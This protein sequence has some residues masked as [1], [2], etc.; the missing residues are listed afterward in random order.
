[1]KT[2]LKKDQ[3]Y[4]EIR[5]RIAHGT[6]TPGQKLPRGVD[7]AKEMGVSHI[8][9]RSA[10]AALERDGLVQSI[11]GRGTFVCR[12]PNDVVI[13]TI[14]LIMP[15][16]GK[17]LTPEQSPT[18][19]SLVSSLMAAAE[20]RQF[21]VRTLHRGRRNFDSASIRNMGVDGL[22]VILPHSSDA[23]MLS[24]LR[25]LGLPLLLFNLFNAGL[26]RWHHCVNVDFA[27]I[28]ADSV[29][30]LH[31]QGRLEIAFASYYDLQPDLPP[32]VLLHG[33]LARMEELGLSPTIVQPA[34]LTYGQV[35][36][37]EVERLFR[38]LVPKLLKV[39]A[40]VATHVEDGMAVQ[41]LLRE[42][43][44]K[45]PQDAAVIGCFDT[46]AM[47]R[48]GITTWR[49]PWADIGSI[50]VE[51][52]DTLIRT[53]NTPPEVILVPGEMVRRRSA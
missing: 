42:N 35:K 43:G 4:E 48:E 41:S 47:E 7:L 21:E 40:V 6:L 24:E 11:H 30:Y 14:G 32:G 1:M 2:V 45:V 9:L 49:M 20:Q 18:Q 8:T 51:R 38:S 33:Y 17:P 25:G 12:D 46:P 15:S 19:F 36:L 53:P 44:M 13:R 52:M 27:R 23:S 50:L 29:S 28:A 10:M 39:D 3:A 5:R 34:A 31:A 16:L 37:E 26:S 22:V